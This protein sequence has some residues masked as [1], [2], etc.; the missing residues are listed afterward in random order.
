VQGPNDVQGD[1]LHGGPG[2]DTFKTRDGER[3]VIDCGPGVDTALIDFKDVLANPAECEV[4]NRARRARKGEDQQ[5]SVD[6]AED[7]NPHA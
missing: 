7:L 4:V 5:E 2:N 6:P 1:V 3:D